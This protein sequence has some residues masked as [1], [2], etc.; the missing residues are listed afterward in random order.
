MAT[1]IF[2]AERFTLTTSR[3]FADVVGTLDRAIGHPNLPELLRRMEEATSP[4][5]LKRLVQSALGPS[6]LMELGRYDFGV[7]LRK[8][9]PP[10]ERS[11]LRLVLGNPLIMRE[12]VRSVPDAG[13]YAPVTV[14]IDERDGGVHLAYDRMASLLAPFGEAHALQV[15]R[16]LDAKVEGLLNEA[17]R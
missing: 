7:V 4:D 12:M 15:A 11:S 10:T 14:L 6:G 3:A 8:D 1:Q 9:H 13:S 16:D 2:T 5:E 17:A